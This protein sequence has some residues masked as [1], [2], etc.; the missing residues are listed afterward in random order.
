MRNSVTDR[1]IVDSGEP[2]YA[3]ASRHNLSELAELCKDR[4]RSLQSD[5]PGMTPTTRV[6]TLHL[7][8]RDE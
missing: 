3:R 4:G 7:A 6:R 5:R 8:R 2:A 1:G